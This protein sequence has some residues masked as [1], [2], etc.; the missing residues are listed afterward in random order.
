MLD[1]QQA[2]GAAPAVLENGGT[3]IADAYS[4]DEEE[5]A[6]GAE[7]LREPTPA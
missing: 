3:M 4:L 1:A 6:A 5:D 2:A 7:A